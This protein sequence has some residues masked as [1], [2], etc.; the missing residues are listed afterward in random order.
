M[1]GTALIR[2][3][4]ARLFAVAALWLPATVAVRA[5][6]PERWA[7]C[8]SDRPVPFDL[9]R[10]QVVVLDSHHHPP[11]GPLIERNRTV[12]A[13]LSLTQM[14]RGRDAFASLQQAGVVLDA[15]PVWTDAHYLDFRRPEWVRTVLEQLVPQALDAGFTGLFLD[16]LDDAEFLEGKDPERYR[17]MRD[18]AVRLVRAIRHQYPQIV[19][20]VNRGYAL[21]PDIAPSID[22]LL[23]ESVLATFDPATK[24]Y[25]RVTDPDVAWQVN[26]LRRAQALNPA[27]KL[28]TL[29]YW[30]PADADGVRRLYQE[31]RAN[32]FVPYVSTPMLDTLV[33][34]PR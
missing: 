14:G 8:Y 23:G 34:E 26:A 16:T 25:S 11:L 29:D 24:A 15:H 13:Y 1:R 3:V 22:I 10:Y 17:G 20:M 32:G 18:A 12:L 4:T 27:L 6:E 31:Q 28:F 21:L 5:A 9:A 19:I 30:D 33:E 2:T 7:V